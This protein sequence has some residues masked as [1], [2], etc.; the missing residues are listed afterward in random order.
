MS[1]RN[2]GADH[3]GGLDLGVN[4][5]MGAAFMQ[6][7]Q[8]QQQSNEKLQKSSESWKPE[9]NSSI[10]CIPVTFQLWVY[11]LYLSSYINITS[12]SPARPWLGVEPSHPDNWIH[13]SDRRVA[14]GCLDRWTGKE[15]DR[16]LRL[17]LLPSSCCLSLGTVPTEEGHG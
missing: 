3:A 6:H 9:E 2:N 5:R 16:G 15:T 1:S 7:Q 14:D 10:P 13:P 8:Y 12:S 11:L 4:R 17:G